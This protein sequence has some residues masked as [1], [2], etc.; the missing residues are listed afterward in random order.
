MYR[1]YVSE[2]PVENEQAPTY[3]VVEIE[4]GNEEKPVVVQRFVNFTE[5]ACYVCDEAPT[6]SVVE[7][8]TGNEEKPVVVQWFVNFTAKNGY[9][10]NRP[11]IVPIERLIGI[12]VVD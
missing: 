10:S 12:S 4:T 7:I 1:V 11:K 8:E 9:D 6:Y 3:S 2:H 5:Q